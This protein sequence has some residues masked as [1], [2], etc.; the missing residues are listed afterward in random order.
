[1]KINPLPIEQTKQG[2]RVLFPDNRFQDVNNEQDAKIIASFPILERQV[3][4][5]TRYDSFLYKEL[6]TMTETRN[7][8]SMNT[9]YVEVLSRQIESLPK[10]EDSVWQD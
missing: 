6:Q 8:Y 1:M 2:W 10:E 9:A 4:S 5:A 3:E 7:R